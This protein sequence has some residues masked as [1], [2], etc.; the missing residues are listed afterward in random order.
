[1]KMNKIVSI[2]SV[3]VVA[4][5]FAACHNSEQTFPD[6]DG[7]T[8]AY[9]A[10]QYPIRT[11]ILGNVETYDNTSDNEG[12]FTIYSTFGGS[13]EGV[14]AKI[15]VKVDESLTEGLYFEDGT[16]VKPMPS[17]YYT[18]SGDVL[19]YGGGFRGGVEIQ[20]NE[21][22][23]NDPLSVKNTYVIPMVMGENFSGV[24]HINRG[25]PMV[26][27]RSAR[28]RPNGISCRRTSQCSV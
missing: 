3:G 21:K 2:L 16:K 11:M 5:A 25:T 4:L 7:G 8:T 15:D 22:F 28:M 26:L 9:F 24:E 19:D 13:Y 6:F 17:D 20:L 14:N 10:Y 1:M 27:R 23:F 18:V 12:R